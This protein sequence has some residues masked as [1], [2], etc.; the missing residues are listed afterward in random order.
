MRRSSGHPA[1]RANHLLAGHHSPG[2]LIIRKNYSLGQIVSHLAL[3]AHAEDPDNL[4]DT[5]DFIP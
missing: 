4:R 2:V 1:K 5:F 3:V